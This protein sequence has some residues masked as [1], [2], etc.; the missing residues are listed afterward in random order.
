[1]G[2]T[3]LEQMHSGNK[4]V[5][6]DMPTIARKEIDVERLWMRNKATSVHDL[7]SHHVTIQR[8]MNL[9]LEDKALIEDEL[10]ERFGKEETYERLVAHDGVAERKVTRTYTTNPDKMPMLREKLGKEFPDYIEESTQ[11]SL[12][13]DKVDALLNALGDEADF[14][15][16]E[17]EKYK[18]RPQATKVLRM[19]EEETKQKKLR[20][21]RSILRKAIDVEERVRIT[22]RPVEHEAKKK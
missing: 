6:F 7:I 13:G 2:K 11:Y 4:Q 12:I 16:S 19:D 18:A 1:M 3:V 5:R 17:E 8:L 10:E 20:G 14:F 9:L 22:V 15:L 21:V